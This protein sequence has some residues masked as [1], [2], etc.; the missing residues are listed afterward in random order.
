M[1][2]RLL[3]LVIFLLLLIYS[4]KGNGNESLE[5][6]GNLM[7]SLMNLSVGPC[8]DFY[9]YA[10][11]NFG[12]LSAQQRFNLYTD[13]FDFRKRLDHLRTDH[14][15]GMV[16]LAKSLNVS[17]ELRVAQRFHNAC[18]QADLYPFPASDPYYLEVIRSIGGFPAVDGASWNASNFSWFNM[19]AHMINYGAQGLI[20]E[21]IFWDYPFSSSL[22]FERTLLGFNPYVNTLNIWSK[23]STAYKQNEKVM[24]GYLRAF[25][26]PED[27]IA[28]VID[29]VFAF[30]RDALRE[31]SEFPP[32]GNCTAFEDN[33]I[34][35]VWN[36]TKEHDSCDSYFVELDKVVT[37]HPEAV[38]NYLAMKLLYAFDAKLEDTKQQ[39][40]Y[41][42]R[43]LR[44]SMM[45]L[46]NK[47]FLE[48]HFTEETKLDVSKIVKEVRQSMESSLVKADWLNSE[49]R[50]GE[51]L[52]ESI[53]DFS[54]ANLLNDYLISETGRLEVVDDSYAAT[55]I[56]L[57]RLSVDINKYNTR[58]TN[59]LFKLPEN[60]HLIVKFLQP[61][62]YEPSWPLSLKFGALGSVLANYLPE[63]ILRDKQGYVERRQCF[64]DYYKNLWSSDDS[65]WREEEIMQF[66]T[67]RLA[68]S[69][70][71]R[72][73]EHLPKDSKQERVNE[74]MPGLD[75]SSN[76][77]FFLGAT[78]VLCA[79][80]IK[81]LKVLAM[82]A[83][84]SNEHFYQAF[85]CPVGSGMRPTNITCHL[86]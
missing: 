42:D 15:L 19:S 26:L 38:A 18:L 10:C 5:S 72:H 30:W 14:L 22:D 50:K 47:L 11:G 24:R 13:P 59:E 52:K 53:L 71:Q 4:T 2:L 40:Y 64:R 41:C 65:K 79:D 31:K 16:D 55:N 32:N 70:Y 49:D 67:L 39:K 3:R 63:N 77:L 51:L 83:L 36:Q 58:Y 45:G 35:I 34:K 44:S 21:E 25:K 54:G 20:G 66:D 82:A 80:G 69:A 76:Q 37:R 62:V 28:E 86:W 56:N 60:I 48:E 12:S 17:S 75:L 33:Y 7:K 84:A 8:D 29:G 46:L 81:L 57:Q 74:T 85:N 73:I 9:E 27:K 6:Y 43:T 68:F 23:G 1:E 78:Q 61:P